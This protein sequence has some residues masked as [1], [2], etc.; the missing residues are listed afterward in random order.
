MVRAEDLFSESIDGMRPS[1]SRNKRQN[2]SAHHS[3]LDDPDFQVDPME[4]DSV[5]LD[6]WHPGT[7]V[8][9]RPSSRLVSTGLACGEL[10][11]P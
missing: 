4:V 9:T 10:E 6:D 7:Q 2:R 1:L 8:C 11:T 5:G 3:D